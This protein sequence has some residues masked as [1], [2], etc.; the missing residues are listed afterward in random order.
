MGPSPRRATVLCS[1]VLVA[2]LAGCNSS[3]VDAPSNPAPQSS[4]AARFAETTGKA[5]DELAEDATENG[6]EHLRVAVQGT[7]KANPG[8]FTEGLE[9]DGNDLLVST[10]GYGTSEVYRTDLAGKRKAEARLD[11]KY[12]GEGITRTGDHVWELTWRSGKALKRKAD[13]LEEIGSTTYSG[14]GWGLCSFPDRIITSDGTPQ[15]RVLDPDT[16]V[17]KDRISVSTGSDPVDSI[18]ELACVGNEVYANRFPT[19]DILRIDAHSGKVTGIID[20]AS[21]DSHAPAD[22][23][24]VLNGIAR[25]PG[26]DTFLLAGKRWP[27]MYEV[28]F[29]PAR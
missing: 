15:L 12:F 19:S 16:F 1:T 11:R 14:E 3:L 2:A 25:F 23:N 17:E 24:N 20:A 10:G 4:S 21:L 27:L 18:N 8:A 6:I 26:R 5:H 7:Y 13:T 9:F 29:V 22:P 28:K